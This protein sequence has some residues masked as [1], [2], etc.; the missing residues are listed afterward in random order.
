MRIF[1]SFMVIF[2]FAYG[3]WLQGTLLKE[4]VRITGEFIHALDYMKREITQKH[5]KLSD[6]LRYLGEK[7]QGFVCDYVNTLWETMSPHEEESFET[8]WR[9]SM[10]AIPQLSSDLLEVLSP[11]G[12][13]LG[14]YDGKSQGESLESV[15]EELRQLKEQQEG[16][17][18]QMVQVYGALGLT[19]GLFVVILLL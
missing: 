12:G 11:L 10:R 9:R 18:R 14:Q 16:K 4:K 1:G 2:G 5:R 13:I 17:C 19:S 8:G 3:G 7:D 6:I 15:I